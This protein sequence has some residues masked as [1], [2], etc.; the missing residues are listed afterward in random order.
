MS[1]ASA[2]ISALLVDMD[3]TLVETESRWYRAETAIMA[4]LGAP[5]SPADQAVLVGGPLS[6]ALN[7]MSERAGGFPTDELG[8][9]LLD[10]MVELLESEPVAWQPGAIEIV[11]EARAAGLPVALV[12][13]STRRL[14][15]AVLGHIGHHHFDTTVAGD[16]TPNPKPDPAPY[17][18]AAERLGADPVR[19]VVLEDSPTGVRAGLDAGAFVVGIPHVAAIE[20]QPRLHL[21]DTLTGV[22]LDDLAG[23][24]ASAG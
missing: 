21:V 17:L 2:Q 6:R 24:A 19:A 14:V 9:L 22:T 1:R 16:E 5:W 7:Y 20:P 11:D 8:V 15:D 3:G 10:R 4:D 23:W 12:S 13:A 18:L